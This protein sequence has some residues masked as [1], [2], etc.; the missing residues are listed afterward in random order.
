MLSQKI[1]KG[2][3]ISKVSTLTSTDVSGLMVWSTNAGTH[4]IDS[5][6]LEK[7]SI[8]QIKKHLP[9]NPAPPSRLYWFWSIFHL[10]LK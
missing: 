9:K 6:T 10:R 4:K 3:G 7:F 5:P 8:V 1:R 2:F